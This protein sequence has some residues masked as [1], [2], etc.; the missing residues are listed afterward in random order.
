MLN[1]R[2]MVANPQAA[3][4]NPTLYRNRA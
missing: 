4:V 1:H 2:E 3:A